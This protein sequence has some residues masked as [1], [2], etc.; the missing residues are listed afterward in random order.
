ML[1]NREWLTSVSMNTKHPLH[2]GKC[3]GRSYTHLKKV[4]QLQC[5]YSWPDWLLCRLYTKVQRNWAATGSWASLNIIIIIIEV[6][7]KHDLC[8]NRFWLCQKC[9]NRSKATKIRAT[10]TSA[11][12]RVFDLCAD[13]ECKYTRN[14]D[15]IQFM[16]EQRCFPK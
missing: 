12:V 3:I 1:R 13:M 6:S 15:N 4:C 10:F 14:T 8:G 16:H 11:F 5:F 9:L 2:S 7:L